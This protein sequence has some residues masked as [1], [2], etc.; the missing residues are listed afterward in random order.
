MSR[1]ESDEFVL[2]FRRT[3]A[4]KVYELPT[5]NEIAGLFKL[6][7][8]SEQELNKQ[9]VVY[10]KNPIDN[11]N[12]Y[13]TINY[14]D[15]YMIPLSYPVLFPHCLKGWHFK[16]TDKKGKHVTIADYASTYF[17]ILRNE[18]NVAIYSKFLG[19]QFA[20]EMN[21]VIEINDLNFHKHKVS[22]LHKISQDSIKNP[23]QRDENKKTVVLSKTFYRS[24]RFYDDLYLNVMALLRE[25]GNPDYFI[26]FTVNMAWPEITNNLYP[27]QTASDRPDLIARVFE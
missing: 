7:D 18:F 14:K 22:S 27:G 2:V 9:F 10:L 24:K 25:K 15:P 21:H 6:S 19:H 17:R 1:E 5:A 26:T 13:L 8:L 3:K 23:K 16:M 4:D 12:N 11:R 20:I